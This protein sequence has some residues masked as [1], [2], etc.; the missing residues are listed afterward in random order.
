MLGYKSKVKVLHKPQGKQ[1]LQI[2]LANDNQLEEVVVEA[3][4]PQHGTTEE[5]KVEATKRNPSVSGN[6]VEE[7]CKHRQE[8]LPIPN[9]RRSIMYEVERSMRTLYI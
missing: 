9:F 7:Y 4:A 1:T 8:C 3:H 2:Q 5:I 6:A